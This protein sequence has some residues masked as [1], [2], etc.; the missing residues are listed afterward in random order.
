MDPRNFGPFP[1][2]GVSKILWNVVRTPDV[3]IQ[4][5]LRNV[6][7]LIFPYRRFSEILYFS[8]FHTEDYPKCCT[9]D[10]SIQKILRNDVLLIFP[11]RRFSEML[12]FWSFHTEDSPKCCTSDLSIQKKSPN[13]TS[14]FCWPYIS[15]YD[16]NETNLMHY[17]SSVYS[18]TIPLHVSGLLV[19]HHQEV[20]THIC[21][22]WYVLYVLVDCPRPDS[23][24]RRTTRTNC[25]IRGCIQNIPEWRCTIHKPHHQTLLKTDHF[26]PATCN[27]AH[28]LIR[29]GS[30]TIYWCFALTQLLY[31]WRYQSGILC[32]HPRMCTLLPPVLGL[33]ASLKHVEV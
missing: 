14:M 33:L 11:Y 2:E 23:R 18:V 3:S 12:Y 9:S 24:L 6:V 5:I 8:S 17:L 28:W 4:K 16:C 31:K 13:F 7:L 20:T 26:H 1:V 15:I 30:P 22:N 27:L 32:M 19:A 10:L 25:H 21:N 29:H